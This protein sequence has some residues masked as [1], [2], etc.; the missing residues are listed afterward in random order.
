[1]LRIKDLSIKVNSRLFQSLAKLE[2]LNFNCSG[3]GNRAARIP[4]PGRIDFNP[5]LFSPYF[6]ILNFNPYDCLS[7]L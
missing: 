4:T 7:T 6:L 5:N 2:L 1:M 3:H